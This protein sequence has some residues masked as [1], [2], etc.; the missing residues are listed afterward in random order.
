M[1]SEAVKKS[2]ESIVGKSYADIAVDGRTSRT[3]FITQFLEKVSEFISLPFFWFREIV[4]KADF[5]Y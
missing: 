1:D 3:K 5:Q 2:I 4:G